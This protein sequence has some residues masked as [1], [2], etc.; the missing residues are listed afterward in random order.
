METNT[1]ASS[2]A[3][4]QTVPFEP[5]KQALETVISKE[6]AAKEA[7]IMP[8][9][10]SNKLQLSSNT[11]LSVGHNMMAS[12]IMRKVQGMSPQEMKE[13]L[14]NLG[15]SQENFASKMGNFLANHG[16]Q[17]K[18]AI[19]QILQAA[20]ISVPD[21]QD[22]LEL[23]KE[24]MSVNPYLLIISMNMKGTQIQNLSLGL[25]EQHL[26][27]LNRLANVQAQGLG[28]QVDNISKSE[29][30]SSHWWQ[31]ALKIV[32]PIVVGVVVGVGLNFVV[33]GL[34]V[35]AD[36]ALG[37][38]EVALE[39]GEV[40]EGVSE[41]VAATKDLVKTAGKAGVKDAVSTTVEESVGEEMTTISSNVAEDSAGDMGSDGM[42]MRDMS[43]ADA[44]PAVDI[45]AVTH[46]EAK[47]AEAEDLDRSEQK[48][49]E[50]LSGMLDG[51]EGPEEGPKTKTV[52]R[53]D[54]WTSE[55]KMK[56]V[57]K[58]LKGLGALSMMMI[59]VGVSETLNYGSNKANNEIAKYQTKAS[60]IS[61]V[62]NNY[63]TQIQAQNSQIQ[64]INQSKQTLSYGMAD[65]LQAMM[66]ETPP[67]QG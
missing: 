57:H 25:T 12:T 20:G 61:L 50:A 41:G 19:E 2:V 53:S 4:D 29:K 39:A 21:D 1:Q 37:A 23:Y 60:Q 16:D 28:D 8:H 32:V 33:P 35:L 5:T 64:T 3:T 14:D 47:A 44:D 54:T 10:L 56:Y 36:A 59:P 7:M 17:I 24:V 48:A 52:K 58:A 22:P 13:T 65:A 43:G 51:T 11:H 66:K 45:E 9:T 27:Q 6:I 15:F 31:T 40:A 34:G 18:P 30:D 62:A 38:G 49:Q 67:L 26:V 46:E 55:G 63:Q 42:E